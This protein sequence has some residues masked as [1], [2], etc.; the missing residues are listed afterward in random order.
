M[1]VHI[2]KD[3]TEKHNIPKVKK[4]ENNQLYERLEE[5]IKN[6]RVGKKE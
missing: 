2:L 5:I 1:I 6:I 4:E 3:G